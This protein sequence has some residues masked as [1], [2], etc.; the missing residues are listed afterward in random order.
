MI[1]SKM[2]DNKNAFM[3]RCKKKREKKHDS[4]DYR[5]C[6]FHDFIHYLAICLN[7]TIASVGL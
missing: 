2:L 6:Y 5:W 4:L 1:V 3:I 7:T